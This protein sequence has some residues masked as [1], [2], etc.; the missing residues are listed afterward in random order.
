MA[1]ASDLTFQGCSCRLLEHAWASYRTGPLQFVRMAQLKWQIR[2]CEC[3]SE[4][5]I[6]SHL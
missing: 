1:S 4:G 5:F 6:D 3:D 2:C